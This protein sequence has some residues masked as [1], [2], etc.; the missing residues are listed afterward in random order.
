[1]TKEKLFESFYGFD[2]EWVIPED[3]RSV[4]VYDLANNPKDYRYQTI[5]VTPQA[6]KILKKQ[7]SWNQLL[8]YTVPVDGYTDEDFLKWAKDSENENAAMFGSWHMSRFMNKTL[9]AG[10]HLE[11]LVRK[12]FTTPNGRHKKTDLKRDEK[13]FRLIELNEFFAR[14]KENQTLKNFL[15]TDDKIEDFCKS[16]TYNNYGASSKNLLSTDYK[17]MRFNKHFSIK[18]RKIILDLTKEELQKV[19]L[20]RNTNPLKNTPYENTGSFSFIKDFIDHALGKTTLVQRNVLPHNEIQE[21]F[22]LNLIK[23]YNYWKNSPENISVHKRLQS[24]GSLIE[25]VY[26]KNKCSQEFLTY[27]VEKDLIKKYNPKETIA[28]LIGACNIR[29]WVSKTSGKD[30]REIAMEKSDNEEISMYSLLEFISYI[31]CN[32]LDAVSGVNF[33]W[34]SFNGEVPAD[35]SYSLFPTVKSREPRFYNFDRI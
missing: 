7:V 19:I 29:Y 2:K 10:S 13:A 20:Q 16:F 4:R 35:W 23:D 33:D 34:A 8:R 14:A 5:R 24:A 15:E 21:A 1:M 31:I 22:T 6:E 18:A 28:I 26:D 32:D 11:Q 9:V 30:I 17:F 3:I 27:L 12:F 25:E